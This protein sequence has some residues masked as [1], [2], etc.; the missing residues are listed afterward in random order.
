MNSKQIILVDIDNSISAT[1]EKLKEVVPGFTTERYPF[2]FPPHF[3]EES[4]IF[5]DVKPVKGAMEKL[6][7]WHDKGHFIYYVT[8]RDSS[9]FHRTVRWLK[10][11]GFPSSLV[12]CSKNKQRVA[13]IIGATI[14]V[15]DA[16]NEIEQLKSVVARV[17]VPAHDYNKQYEN[18]FFNWSDVAI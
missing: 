12:I 16:P 7:E 8:A 15:D 13:S 2:P 14:A 10:K 18:R 3:F 17:L 5:D 4:S 6:K 11:H 1:N 9:S